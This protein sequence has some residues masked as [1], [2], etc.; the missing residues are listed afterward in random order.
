MSLIQLIRSCLLRFSAVEAVLNTLTAILRVTMTSYNACSFHIDI[1]ISIRVN[2]RI[3]SDI[4]YTD[5][6]TLSDFSIQLG[7]GSYKIN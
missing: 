4:P 1:Y 5:Y 7:K 2:N 3:K 6:F